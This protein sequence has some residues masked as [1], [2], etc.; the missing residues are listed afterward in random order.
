MS[1]LENLSY[2]DFEELCRDLALAETGERF[3]A[4][5]PGPD[6]GID[7]RHSK[8]NDSTI[9]QCKHYWRSSFSNLKS[10]LQREV[11][12][13]EK[14]KPNRYLLF[15]SQSL[16][17]QKS[18]ILAEILG[19]WLK[20]LE[21][22]WGKE[23]IEASIRRHP[24][25]EKSHMKLWLSSTA[26]LERILQSGLETFTDTTKEEIRE[27]LSVYVHNRSFNDAI[28][29]LEAQKILIISG[30]PGVGKTTLAKMISYYYLR[31]NWRFYAINS[32][33]DGFSTIRDDKPML[34]YFDDFLGRIDLDRQSLRQSD[35]AFAT[36]IKRVARSKNARF[37]LTT[38]AHIFEEARLLSDYLDDE[39][40]QLSKYVLDVG[41]YSRK[42]RSHILFNHLSVSDLT[43]AHFES[44]L[45]DEWL[46]KIIDHRNYN[47]RVIAS[48]S[49]DCLNRVEPDLYPA[50]IYRA[51]EDPD[52]IWQ[53]PF[54]ALTMKCQNLLVCLYFGKVNGESIETL[55]EIFSDL[56]RN[57]CAFYSQPAKPNDFEDA[58]R[59]L[60]SGFVSLSG[61]T[62]KLI[63]PSL[64][65]FLKA[66]LVDVDLLKLLTAGS[67]RAD[68]ASK[69]WTHIKDKYK[70]HPDTLLTFAH[71]F[72]DYAE[73][74]S[75]TPSMKRN[76]ERGVISYSVDDLPISDKVELF[77]EWW[78][79]T[80]DDVL[81]QR[82]LELL[83]SDSLS[84]V[85]ERD[86]QS[87]PGLWW[88][89]RKHLED[90]HLLKV[91]VLNAIECRLIEVLENGVVTEDLVPIVESVYAHMEDAVPK[92]LQ[93]VLDQALDYE[94]AVV[95]GAI[96]ELDCEQSLLEH[97]DHVD[98]LAEITGRDASEVKRVINC[99]VA[100]I[101]EV[102]WQEERPGF[103]SRPVRDDE[104]FNDR[105]LYSLF[106]NLVDAARP[107]SG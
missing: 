8:G 69:L 28:A 3:S 107:A 19:K 6:E 68:W 67:K 38:R 54:R 99:R 22:I 60:E 74:I 89:L 79:H 44:L 4:F 87:L 15:T 65:D 102:N 80:N 104:Q 72:L 91:D 85:I 57:V 82:S 36:F 106:S 95:G 21:D 105:A 39:R 53:K 51:L 42:I 18:K 37:I 10:A 94:F 92:R 27:Q 40:L 5:G 62:A 83:K 43:S 47:P 48:I 26:V 9:L 71:S 34:F 12:K 16:T 24:D 56:H 97:S 58:L 86:G 13:L 14:L 46:K 1:Y 50:Y 55:R 41:V 103:V 75:L 63:N 33:E 88:W 101:L 11:I 52:L 73:K 49:S 32:L 66:H 90:E 64:R 17:P 70:T 78:E 96:D 76:E 20:H 35:S 23:D 2:I 45:K 100:E 77:L 93:E 29:R 59:S 61:K 25:I 31:D 7:G 81:I 98:A 84:L 30:P